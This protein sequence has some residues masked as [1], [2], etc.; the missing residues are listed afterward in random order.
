MRSIRQDQLTSRTSHMGCTARRLL[1]KSGTG[2]I[3]LVALSS[4]RVKAGVPTE[5]QV[6]VAYLC[7]LGRFVQWPA[8][9]GAKAG[10]TFPICVLGMDPFGRSLDQ[11]IAGQA[12]DGMSVIARRIS[13]PEQALNCRVLFI[14]SSEDAALNGVLST[15]GSAGVL[16]VSDMPQFIERGGMVGLVLQHN[17]VRFEVNL[18]AA[19]S[20]GLTLSS[21]LLKLAVNVKGL[22]QSG[23]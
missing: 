9:G 21:Q 6:K 12:I 22:D 10:P 15:L 13:T 8:K 4:P 11:A 17:R 20:A 3:L 14:S 16:T 23:G 5:Y 7:N 1:L 19:K 2:M 18:A